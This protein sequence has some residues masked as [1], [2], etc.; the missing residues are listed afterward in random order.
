MMRKYMTISILLLGISPI[1]AQQS[2]DPY[3]IALVKAALSQPAGFSSSFVEKYMNRLGDGVAIALLKIFSADELETPQMIHRF[4]PVIKEAFQ[5]PQLISLPENRKP[6]V[7]LFLLGNIQ[8]QVSDAGAKAEIAGL[9]VF[10][11]A[12]ME[13][14]K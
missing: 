12:Q 11:H 4:V 10:I 5:A 1:F 13:I 9:I 14:V 6:D 8:R 2:I 3:S 7:T